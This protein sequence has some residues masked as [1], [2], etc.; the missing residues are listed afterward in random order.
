MLN[1][2]LARNLGSRLSTLCI[3]NHKWPRLNLK[4]LLNLFLGNFL[5]ASASIMCCFTRVLLF[6]SRI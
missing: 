6:A 4:R 2:N 3:E 1:F 5:V